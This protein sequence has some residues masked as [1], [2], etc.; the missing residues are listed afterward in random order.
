MT[1]SAPSPSTS[2]PYWPKAVAWWLLGVGALVFV[3]VVVGGITRLTE[4]G[5]SMVRWEPI[6]GI[7]P[8]L[9]AE[10]WQAELDAYRATPEY[11]QVNH[12]MSMAEFQAIFFWE[13][14]HR[15]LG[16]LIGLAFA[17]PLA[18]FWMKKAIPSGYHLRLVALLALG[19]LQGAIG[20]WMVAS[21]LVDRPDVSHIRLAVHL[22][23]ALLI[24]GGLV[25]TALDL[26]ALHRNADAR[27]ARMTGFGLVVILILAVQIMLG[28]FTA[29]LEAGYAFSTWPMMGSEWFP[30]NTPM[31]GG[32]WRNFVDNPI[33]VQFSHR[34][35]A[36]VTVIALVWLARKVRADNRVA[37]VAIH[38]AFGTQFLLGIATLL[39]GVNIAVATAHQGVGALV[40]VTT[41]WGVH[42]IGRPPG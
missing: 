39:T 6:S 27:P 29:G 42:L 15:V 41:V 8:P 12:G 4:S 7:I 38:S 3:M 1:G 9:N 18:W 10:Q 24:L 30:A 33:V 13:Y 17:L 37:S 25:W 14:L 28:A 20:W 34:W 5:L 21:G 36:V 19:G 11:I 35:W 31:L 26:F 16:R 23:T 2:A 22:M 32:F 40:V